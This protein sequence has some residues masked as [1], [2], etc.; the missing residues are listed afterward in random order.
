MADDGLDLALRIRADFGRAVGELRR[1]ESGID[2]AGRAAAAADRRAQGFA[3]AFDRASSALAAFAAGGRADFSSLADS[4]LADLARIAAARVLPG[5]F[6][7][8]LGRIF[9][10]PWAAPWAGAGA[11]AR[12]YHGGGVAGAAGGRSRPPGAGLA[13]DEV[14]AVLR[15]GEVVLPAGAVGAAAPALPEI[16]ISFVNQ[17]TPQREV[18]SESRFDGRALIVSVVT[19]DIERRGPIGRAIE[20][21]HGLRRGTL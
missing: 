20:G 5:A 1:L 15:R 6:G 21:V 19:D 8:A 9:A 4:I 7:G 3:G 17:G 10:A 18:G 16:R 12:V 11:S 2:G 14:A 13:A